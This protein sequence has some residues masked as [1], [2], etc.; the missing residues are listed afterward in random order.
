M[1]LG[2]LIVNAQDQCNQTISSA[3]GFQLN[4]INHT[5]T[6]GSPIVGEGVSQDGSFSVCNGFVPISCDNQIQAEC[7]TLLSTNVTTNVACSGDQITFTAILNPVDAQNVTLSVELE[8]GI[9]LIPALSGPN[10]SGLYSGS[11]TLNNT[12]CY[13]E[14]QSFLI[15]LKCNFDNST[16]GIETLDVT[17]YPS[18]IEQFVIVE[19]DNCSASVGISEECV[20]IDGITY[21]NVEPSSYTAEPGESGIW[22]INY[23]FIDKYGFYPCPEYVLSGLIEY[24]YNCYD[25]CGN[26]AGEM[27]GSTF[28]CHN[29]FFVADID[30]GAVVEAGSTQVYV[31]HDGTSS[32]I[33][34]NIYAVVGPGEP[35]FNDGGIPTN[36]SL[37][38]SSIVGDE[39]D[40]NGIP[41]TVGCYDISDDCK[42]IIFL[43]PI[44]IIVNEICDESIGE[45]IVTFSISGGGIG[46]FPGHTY[47]VTGTYNGEVQINQVITLGP[48]A[49]GDSYSIE[50][51]DDGKGCRFETDG[52]LMSCETNPLPAISLSKLADASGVINPAE[53]GQ[54]INYS[55]YV[56]NTGNVELTNIIVND[57][58]VAVS[59]EPISLAAGE[60]DDTS[61]IA[62]YTITS[63]DITSGDVVNSATASGTDPFGTVVN[64]KDIATVTFESSSI[65]CPEVTDLGTYDCTNIQMVPPQVNT[66]EEVM[67]SPYNLSIPDVIASTSVQM[68]DSD[69]IFYCEDNARTI[70]RTITIYNDTNFNSTYDAGEELGIC[71]FTINTIADVTAP[72]FEAPANFNTNCAA[73]YEP[74]IT[75]N[76][77]VVEDDNCTV[78]FSGDYISYADAISEG[79]CIG[80]LFVTRSWVATDPCGNSS[81]P[82]TQMITV[83]DNEGPVFTVP[84]NVTLNCG[85][86]P[87]DES[88]SGTVNDATDE[89]DPTEIQVNSIIV[90]DLTQENIPCPG[91]TTYTKRWGAVDDCGNTTTMDQIIIVECQPECTNDDSNC[92]TISTYN[93]EL[94]SCVDEIIPTSNPQFTGSCEEG[95]DIALVID[96]SAKMTNY[97]GEIETAVLSFLN[98]LSCYGNIR[99]ALIEFSSEA[100]SVI[101]DY[102][103]LSEMLYDDIGGY[104]SFRALNNQ[105]YTPSG[106]ANWDAAFAKVEELANPD[107]MPIN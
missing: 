9:V 97:A 53:P 80:E 71:D 104:F 51:D 93:T 77:T 1:L 11:L 101:P 27:R 49:M 34:A 88:L 59:G 68:E 67:N 39:P 48:F 2:Y 14:S 7:P 75:G 41:Q 36:V 72:T 35:I 21:L 4:S 63:A 61:F 3:G 76:V 38:F 54:V 66:L 100:H 52:I 25:P 12:G 95:F 20:D 79:S 26:S 55:F 83:I 56:C 73:G 24:D 106:T 47:S 28:V 13:P 65:V 87:N 64:D 74:E 6:I 81:E 57:D 78:P 43:D 85:S 33:G 32:Q 37:C 69:I 98:E 22:T 44:N 5:V 102:T 31:L 60:C 62:F 15:R 40:A 89:C 8:S 86:D 10:P 29:S 45:Y 105:L 50:V 90:T 91:S 103:N 19:G 84:A 107:L 58:L 82:Q 23:T 99:I 92:A 30:N 18:S 42:S 17:V 70:I 46:F 16:S 96:E 94:C